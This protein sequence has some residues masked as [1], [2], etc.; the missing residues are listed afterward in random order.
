MKQTIL[1][2]GSPRKGNTDFVLS[3]IAKKINGKKELLLLR[4]LKIGFC[5]GC[6]SCDIKPKCVLD[7]DMKK[8]FN[9][10][11]KADLIVIGSP[12]YYGNVSAMMKNF[13]DRTIPA[14]EKELLKEKKLISIMVG[15]EKVINVSNY[16]REAVRGFVIHNRLNLVAMYNFQALEVNDLAKNPKSKIEIGKII[17]KI[18]FIK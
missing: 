4:D 1:I 10:L 14:Y 9:K 13:I 12:L 5:N 17:K 2:S 8:L 15:G 18:N 11:L 3:E 7:D 16:H 6:R